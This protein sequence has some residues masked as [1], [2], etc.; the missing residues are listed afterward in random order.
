M[1]DEYIIYIPIINLVNVI[2]LFSTMHK[3]TFYLTNAKKMSIIFKLIFFPTAFNVIR[4]FID[5][6]IGN[7]MILDIILWSFIAITLWMVS[8]IAERE[9]KS[10]IAY[11][12]KTNQRK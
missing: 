2:K 11:V 6:W 5:M 3:H 8:Y 12:K 7:K 9:R 4:I 10:I 1:L